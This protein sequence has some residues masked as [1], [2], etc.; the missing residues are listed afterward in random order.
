MKKRTIVFLCIFLLT[1][2]V[3]TASADGPPTTP[4]YEDLGDGVVITDDG[5]E[6]NIAGIV[7]VAVN[8][9]LVIGA[10][11]LLINVK[12]RRKKQIMMEKREVE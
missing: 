4:L 1:F 9:I 8:A 12:R 5:D 6:L 10:V 11:I 2:C 3:A 7:I